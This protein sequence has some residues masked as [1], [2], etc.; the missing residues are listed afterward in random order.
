MMPQQRN[1]LTMDILKKLKEKGMPEKK[2]IPLMGEDQPDDL[3][4]EGEIP[5]PDPE[6]KRENDETPEEIPSPDGTVTDNSLPGSPLLSRLRQ[7][8]RPR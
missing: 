4:S 5:Q 2:G 8:K 6:R 1:S 7:R 3:G